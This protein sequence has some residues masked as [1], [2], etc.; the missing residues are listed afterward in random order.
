MPLLRRGPAATMF[1]T[2]VSMA[3]ADS[4]VARRGSPFAHPEDA[5]GMTTATPEERR[6]N[7]TH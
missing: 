2:V 7:P 6:S 3:V 1:G 5:A 4:G